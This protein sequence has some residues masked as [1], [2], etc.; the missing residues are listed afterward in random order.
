VTDVAELRFGTKFI[1][2]NK[3]KFYLYTIAL[4]FGTLF[5]FSCKTE[6]K[7]NTDF[8]YFQKG[9]DSIQQLGYTEPKFKE[10]D[11]ISIQVIAG[12]IRQEDAALYNLAT[13]SLN[14]IGN[15]T[16]ASQVSSNVGYE[17][18]LNGNIELP[19]IGKV[20]A[21]GLTKYE[22]AEAV[23]LKL[24]DEVKNPLVVVKYAQYKINVLGEVRKPGAV[25][26]KTEKV[27]ILDA[28]AEAGDL[29][30]TA[31]R[32]DILVMRNTN[33]KYE[34]YKIN[35]TNTSFMS[36]PAFFLQQN[37]VVYVGANKLKLQALAEQPNSQRN[38]QLFITA[39]SSLALLINSIY[40]IKRG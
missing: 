4:I 9:L 14:S 38:F 31:K 26:F 2:M 36:S 23:R 39:I 11:L 28:I 13:G 34:T 37:D 16:A 21:A 35:L 22:L 25:I 10:S 7:I 30:E 32:E 27:N 6:K 24:V 20:K 15:P 18:D 29:N 5:L 8:N 1:Q 17:I 33:N 19:K 40:I 3:S 12:S